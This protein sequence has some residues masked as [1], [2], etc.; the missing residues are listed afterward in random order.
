MLIQKLNN[1]NYDQS[2]QIQTVTQAAY[3]Q[4]AALLGVD[5]FPPLARTCEDVMSDLGVYIGAFAGGVLE[6][7]LHLEG[8]H[9][10]VLTVHP[11]AQRRGIASRLLDYV[12]SDYRK[13]VKKSQS[14]DDAELVAQGRV[15]VS[16]GTL[17]FP[18]LALYQKMGF[19]E[20]SRSLKG[21]IELTNLAWTVCSG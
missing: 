21:N 5:F 1:K 15:T 6:G 11:R 2:L 7:V 10:N 12:L 8:H 17:N 16:T 9:I 14:C 18:A 4:E 3:R 13:G 20:V 19:E